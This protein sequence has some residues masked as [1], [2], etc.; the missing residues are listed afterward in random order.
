MQLPALWILAA[1]AAGIGIATRLDIRWMPW[2]NA[3]LDFY[4]RIAMGRRL[5][6]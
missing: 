3:M 6:R 5:Q 1:L 4:A 2:R